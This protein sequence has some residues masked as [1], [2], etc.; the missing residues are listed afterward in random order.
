MFGI[1]SIPL[2]IIFL[3]SAEFTAFDPIFRPVLAKLLASPLPVCPFLEVLYL[4]ILSSFSRSDV[5]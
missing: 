1:L 5:K 3:P 2:F 4:L